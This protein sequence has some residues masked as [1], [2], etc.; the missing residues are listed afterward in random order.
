MRKAADAMDKIND[1]YGE[2]T[3]IPGLM[4]DTDNL[5]LDRIA[6]GKVKDLEE[7]YT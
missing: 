7:I 1:T 3:I 5:I 2:F 6:F 4:L